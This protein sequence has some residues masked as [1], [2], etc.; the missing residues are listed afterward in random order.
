MVRY[1]VG[2]L[3]LANNYLANGDLTVVVSHANDLPFQ[4]AIELE[5]G[6]IVTLCKVLCGR[7]KII[8]GWRVL[9]RQSVIGTVRRRR[10]LRLG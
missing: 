1:R 7:F 10:W 6:L 5:L 9:E 3:S 8:I 4:V 2:W